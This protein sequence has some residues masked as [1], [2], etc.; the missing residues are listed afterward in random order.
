[1][2]DFVVVTKHMSHV[3][4]SLPLFLRSAKS[5][6]IGVFKLFLR[7]FLELTPVMEILGDRGRG[8]SASLEGEAFWRPCHTVLLET[9]AY[10]DVW[11]HHC[12]YHIRSPVGDS[13]STAH[14]DFSLRSC[15]IKGNLGY[16]AV[17]R[18]EKLHF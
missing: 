13:L 2:S 16:K 12:L 15:K 7:S 5:Y 11:T 17:L 3:Y 14:W 1:M 4:T 10:A 8:V 18:T 9:D 6:S